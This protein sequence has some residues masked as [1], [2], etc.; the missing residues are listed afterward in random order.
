MSSPPD[1]E[2]RPGVA[3]PG[4]EDEDISFNV[5]LERME[6]LFEER[7]ELAHIHTFA[8]S[9][10]VAPWALLGAV[11]VHATCQV[12]PAFVLP[13]IIGGEASLNTFA[14]LVGPSGSGKTAAEGVARDVFTFTRTETRHVGSGE[15]LVKAYARRAKGVPKGEMAPP[16]MYNTRI[17]WRAS[18][19]DTLTALAA[20]QGSTLMSRLRDAWMGDQLGFAYADADKALNLD[21]H[22]YRMGLILGVQ[23]AKAGPLINDADGGTPQRFLWFPVT[24]R[25]M[26]DVRDRPEEPEPWQWACPQLDTRGHDSRSGLTRIKVCAWAEDA[27]VEA[28]LARGRGEVVETALDGHALLARLK[29][30]AALG[31]LAGRLEVTDEDWEL[32]GVVMEVSTATRQVVVDRLARRDRAAKRHRAEDDSERA[33]I[34]DRAR[35]DHRVMRVADRVKINLTTEWTK[36]KDLKRRFNSRD[37]ALLSEALD[38]LRLAGQI[39]V[40]EVS[41]NGQAGYVYRRRYGP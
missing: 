31:I 11:L 26:P 2:R 28:H 27:I 8:R 17:L 30:A 36:T 18:E 20:R 35:H 39:E 3:A 7:P 22:T 34:V 15:G 5:A 13:P 1:M 25:L 37:K 29:V 4:P 33:V 12:E 10:S 40:Q 14:A 16:E 41:R 19:V 21:P 32:A 9:R 23:P 6:Y 38:A 24:D